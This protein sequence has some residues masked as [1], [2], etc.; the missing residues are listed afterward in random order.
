M[1]EHDHPQIGTDEAKVIPVEGVGRGVTEQ[2]N[3]VDCSTLGIL[4]ETN[5]AGDEQNVSEQGIQH[6]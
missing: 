4:M 1:P 5:A 2:C 3:F 6:L